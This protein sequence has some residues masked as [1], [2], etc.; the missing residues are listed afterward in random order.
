MDNQL[1]RFPGVFML[2]GIVLFM[3]GLLVSVVMPSVA[4]LNQREETASIEDL[5]AEPAGSGFETLANTY[6]E[7][8]DDIW[9]E[10]PTPANYADALEM[11]R[12]LYIENACFQCHTQQV[13][14]FEHETARYG[15]ESSLLDQDNDLQKPHL[16]GLRR[17]G[18]D[19][20]RAGRQHDV[21]YW[22]QYL[23]DPTTLVPDAAMPAYP[24][25]FEEEGI[26]NEEGFAMI[27]YLD[28]LGDYQPVPTEDD[29]SEEEQ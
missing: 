26:P 13:R 28:W 1:E 10:G 3:V 19:L 4:I 16:L 8:F 21:E 22:V 17:I 15:S 23:Y 12:D 27:A 29:E 5:A 7:E 20:A 6:P 9:P 14:P 25:F 24:W 18:P 2:G 11:G